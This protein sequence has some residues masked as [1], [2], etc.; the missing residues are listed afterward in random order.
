MSG[1]ERCWAIVGGD[2]E[3]YRE[4]LAT[5]PDCTPEQQAGPYAGIC[6]TCG[7][8]TLHQYSRQC[9]NGCIFGMTEAQR[10]ASL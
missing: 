3:R 8:A 9:M 7:R 10:L 4:I 2:A 1:C 5:N 6:V